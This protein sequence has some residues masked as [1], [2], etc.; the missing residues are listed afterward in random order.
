MKRLTAGTARHFTKETLFDRVARAVCEAECLPRKELY[1]T[2]EVARRVIRRFRGGR[3]VDLAAGHG[4]LAYVMCLLDPSSEGAIAAD[5]SRPLSAGRLHDALVERWPQL[6]SKVRY[7]ETDI[8]DVEVRSTDAVLSVHA[9]G[10]LSD[11]V[12]DLAISAK[13]RVAILPCCHSKRHS[14]TGGLLGW[15]DPSLAIDVTRAAR[16]A[17]A[18]YRVHTAMIPETITPKARLLFGHPPSDALESE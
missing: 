18:G 8:R 9:C 1:E 15:M 10:A 11:R 12:L 17:A 3:F 13:A 14:N 2:W 6:T 7:I 5:K 16:L 4:L